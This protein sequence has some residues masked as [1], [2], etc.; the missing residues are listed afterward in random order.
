VSG[1]PPGP[2]VTARGIERFYGRSVA[3]TGI[4]L[5]LPSGLT[6]ALFGANG[7]GKTTLLRILAQVLRPTRG[8]VRIFG[9]DP[10]REQALVLSSLGFLSHE[11]ALYLDL[12]PLENLLFTARLH[13]LDRAR[14]RAREALERVGLADR[15]EPVRALSRGLQQRAA[16][17][18]ALLHD[19]RLLLLD[20]PWT[21]LDPEAQGVL[22]ERLSG[23]RA[24]GG[25]TIFTTHDLGEGLRTA[26]RVVLLSRGRIV[27][28]ADAAGLTLDALAAAYAR[29]AAEG[30][31]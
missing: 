1:A 15:D 7:A 2:A 14:I 19:P 20:E 6:V 8:E 27:L 31:A 18:R 22:R 10:A 11:V 28:Q 26:D 4:D 29:A 12:T 13:G 16:L 23:H 25:T 21:G 5:E 3:L 9:R 17:A 30:R 24:R